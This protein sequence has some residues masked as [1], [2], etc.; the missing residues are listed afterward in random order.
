MFKRREFLKYAIGQCTLGTVALCAPT[1]LL[2]N[3]RQTA[4]PQ[5]LP[6]RQLAFYHLHTGEKLSTTYWS[7]GEYI[8]QEL[9]HLNYLLRDHRTGEVQAMDK[10]LLDLL[11]VL[12]QHVDKQGAYHIIS[13]YRSPKTNAKLRQQS[14]G[15]AK[16][17]LHMQGKA[18]DV[19]LPGV[20][21]K[22][23]RQAALQ[24][25]AGGVGYYPKSN[26]VHIDTGR[27]RFW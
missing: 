16:R 17:S 24:L 14:K 8:A 27:P 3:T 12:Q 1:L 13:G 5:T 4:K 7:E 22:H 25:K 2:A 23:L 10:N 21:L 26:F 20:S 15:V 19:R 18:M 6:D 9:Q 11:Y